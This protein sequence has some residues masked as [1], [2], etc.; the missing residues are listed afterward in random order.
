MKEI[1][2]YSYIKEKYESKRIS[3]VSKG[4]K[5]VESQGG[6]P[7]L[8]SWHWAQ[9]SLGKMPKGRQGHQK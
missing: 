7:G 9:A 3:N 4:K 6:S 2:I 1:S 5:K 8:L